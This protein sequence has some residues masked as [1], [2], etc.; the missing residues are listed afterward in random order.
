MRYLPAG[1]SVLD[2]GAASGIH[3]PLFL[4]MGRML[5]Y[6]GIDISRNFLKIAKR[7]YPQMRFAYG[8][9]L[10]A[11]TLPKKKFDAFWAA[12]VLQHIPLAQWPE[13]LSNI[14]RHMTR[15]AIGYLTVPEERPSP[16]SEKDRRYF[17]LF[18]DKKFRAVLVPRKWRIL[19][20]GARK[21][22]TGGVV[23]RWYIVKLP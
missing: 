7:R 18:D 3:V 19:K 23:W 2:I 20:A 21:G 6:F 1:A 5:K 17:E 4:G 10:D 15:G 9:I 11:E 8:D 22:K 16:A 12:A 13:A 14:E